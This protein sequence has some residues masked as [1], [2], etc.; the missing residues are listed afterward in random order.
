MKDA[1]NVAMNEIIV[2]SSKDKVGLTVLN[3]KNVSAAHNVL[4]IMNGSILKK[5]NP[6]IGPDP[7][8]KNTINEND[9]NAANIYNINNIT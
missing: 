5:L 7:S 1:K 2:I 9:V 8:I 6:P 3:I 4:K